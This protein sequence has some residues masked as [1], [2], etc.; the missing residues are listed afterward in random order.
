MLSY[1]TVKPHTLELLKALAKQPELSETRLVGGTSLALQYGHRSSIDLDFFGNVSADTPELEKMLCKLGEVKTLGQ[2]KNVKTFMLDG[3]KLDIVNYDYP[4]ID[5]PVVED[6]IVLAS[7]KDIAALKINAIEGRGT[8]KDF[9]D[10]YALLQHYTLKEILTFYK[11]KYSTHS[12]FR[13]LLSLSYFDDAD[14]QMMPTMY[15]PETWDVMKR[16]IIEEVDRF[17]E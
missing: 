14:P 5:A 3:V 15:I 1:R 10:V 4:W 12:L 9:I 17:E 8:K 7:T 6:E 13:A 2:N 11:Q 16:Y